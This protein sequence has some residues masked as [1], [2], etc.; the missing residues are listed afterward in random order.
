MNEEIDAEKLSLLDQQFSSIVLEKVVLSDE[1]IGAN[2]FIRTH[3]KKYR[4][5]II[6]G[7][8]TLEM[9]II[10][11]KRGLS[12]YFLGIYGSPK[13]KRYWVE[14][15]IKTH[16][17]IRNESLFLGDANTDLDASTFANIHFALR[18]N[19]QNKEQ[20]IEYD[21]LRFKDFHKLKEL[22]KE[23]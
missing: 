14:Y 20:F 7:T 4:F 16:G 12:Q 21:G 19:D 15:L 9:R 3:H 1:V 22:I 6:T 10:A 11:K 18:E 23:F 2:E 8:P 17:L 13:S 5:W